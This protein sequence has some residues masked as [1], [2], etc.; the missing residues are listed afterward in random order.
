VY[1]T[2][3]I[4]PL[5]SA[6]IAGLL[7]RKIGREGSQAITLLNIIGAML[8]SLI[9]FYEIGYNQSWINI[10]ISPYIISET[11]NI[12]WGFYI[13]SLSIVMLVMV[14]FISTCVHIYAV[15]Y[16]WNDAHNQR[17]MS[18]LS[19]FTFFM[20]ILIT[21]ENLIIIFIGW[22]GVGICSYLLIAYWY[23]RIQANKS[24]MK[25]ILMNR[26]GDWGYSIALYI[27]YSIYGNWNVTLLQS[28]TPIINENI[29]TIITICLLIGAMGKS[30]QLGLHTWLADAMEGPTPVSALIHA[31]TMVTAGVY[32]LLRISP[33]LEYS[34]TS[35]SIIIIIGALTALYS[36]STAIWQTD[37]KKIIAYS[38]CS[39]LG[40]LFI[41]IGCSNQSI[42]IF[43][44]V[45]HAFFKALLF[46]A[47]G[48][49]LHTFNDQQ[50]IKKY[51]GFIHL[52][53]LFYSLVLIGSCSLMA[54]PFLTGYTSKDVL[55]ETS[56]G[57]YIFLGSLGFWWAC[58]TAILT[59]FYSIKI[60]YYTFLSSPNT[61]G[62][63]KSLYITSFNKPKFLK[64]YNVTES[65]NS[66][67]FNKHSTHEC[68]S[69]LKLVSSPLVFV[70]TRV[71]FF[72]FSPLIL[73]AIS[74]IIFG[75]FT[76]FIINSP[77]SSFYG[78]CL[79][80]HPNHISF[81]DSEF[82]SYF[83]K[84]FPLFCTLIGSSIIIFFQVTNVTV[85]HHINTNWF[86]FFYSYFFLYPSL[87]FAY[88]TYKFLDKGFI[89]FLGPSGIIKS[90]LFS[91]SFLANAD[92]GVISNYTIN[93]IL[94]LLL[95]FWIQTF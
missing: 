80:T 11:I 37:I 28:L 36:A 78:N 4:L 12:N 59:A 53:P 73:L 88:Y 32:L 68:E 25:A 27:I 42:G 3:I 38:T 35:L 33:I 39:Q 9:G 46:L 22:E 63:N 61:T 41:A 84:L 70:S 7:G 55:I 58:F 10:K 8:L 83:I 64:S 67:G 47:A 69:H 77:Y 56:F 86:D 30:A 23:S 93:L 48:S 43:H 19:L 65:L 75:F 66:T 95:I 71:Y 76:S 82:L 14:L 2:I 13:D 72:E 60:L 51:G 85:L 90:T 15:N 24:A 45:N 91:S 20:L 49:I 1:L 40:Y 18:Y 29:I 81:I 44:L 87:N 52:N 74:S 57:H 89:E 79:F 31:A 94:A 92:T 16:M 50:D 6:I 17:F 34:S 26:I 54:L 21:G 5:L 62:F